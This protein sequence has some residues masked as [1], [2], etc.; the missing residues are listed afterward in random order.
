M[1]TAKQYLEGDIEL[2]EF[3]DDLPTNQY[4]HAED[5]EY[6]VLAEEDMLTAFFEAKREFEAQE[7]DT[8][9][10]ADCGGEA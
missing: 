10:D 6:G 3:D 7:A 9:V 4:Q 2:L 1:A 5:T 8:E